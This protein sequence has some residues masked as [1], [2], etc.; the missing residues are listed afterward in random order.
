MTVIC[1]N[2]MDGM[3]SCFSEDIVITPKTDAKIVTSA[4]RA[5]LARDSFASRNI[6]WS[7]DGATDVRGRNQTD[8][9][10]ERAAVVLGAD[11]FQLQCLGRVGL[12]L[13][14]EVRVLVELDAIA[15]HHL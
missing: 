7:P 8:R 12:E 1:G 10:P 2:S 3:S 13:G 6:S 14:G 11:R 5:R 15:G 4:I 9:N